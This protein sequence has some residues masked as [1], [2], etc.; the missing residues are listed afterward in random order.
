MPRK[1]NKKQKKQ[2][3]PESID[4]LPNKRKRLEK[5]EK[6]KNP[7]QWLTQ[8][9]EEDGDDLPVSSYSQGSHR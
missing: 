8:V 7:K 3:R 9:D 1:D 2:A 5:K 6:Y 4:E